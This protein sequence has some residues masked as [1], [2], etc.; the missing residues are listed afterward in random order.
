MNINQLTEMGK[1]TM[2]EAIGIELLE[3]GDDYVYGKMPVD[4][5]TIQPYGLLHGGASAAFAE[6]LGSIAGMLKVDSGVCR[7]V[8]KSLNCRHIRSVK[9]G[10]VFGRAVPVD[11]G[12]R[13]H[14]WSIRIN[15]EEG[16]LICS[17]RLALA[18][19]D[20]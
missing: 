16:R 20:V 18:V 10:W 19:I 15:D 14:V 4:H 3:I 13:D 1:G 12:D 7:V 6:T 2:A 8:G 9:N 11:I 5:R 17:C